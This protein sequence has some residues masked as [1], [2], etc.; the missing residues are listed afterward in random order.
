[1]SPLTAILEAVDISHLSVPEWPQF[2][3]RGFVFELGYKR[4]VDAIDRKNKGVTRRQMEALW[5]A[6]LKKKYAT[7]DPRPSDEAQQRQVN[8]N[9]CIG[10]KWDMMYNAFLMR[11]GHY[12]ERWADYVESIGDDKGGSR[13]Q[14]AKKADW[15][16]PYWQKK[17]RD[18][19]G[20]DIRSVDDNVYTAVPPTEEIVA[21]TS[22]PSA[23]KLN[24]V[25]PTAAQ[26]AAKKDKLRA[27]IDA[28]GIQDAGGFGRAAEEEPKQASQG[29]GVIMT[30]LDKDV[31]GLDITEKKR[32]RKNRGKKKREAVEKKRKLAEEEKAKEAEKKKKGKGVAVDDDGDEEF[33]EPWVPWSYK[34][35]DPALLDDGYVDSDGD[36]GMAG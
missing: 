16:E 29:L 21:S 25:A 18:F 36:V 27:F 2:D 8:Y 22:S 35:V 24:N 3:F 32:K 30:E 26:M 14:S 10:Y 7:W 33:S 34:E 13:A 28:G 4:F 19:P 23:E 6:M 5:L 9:I 31:A 15:I 11:S 17:S 12:N 1:M 20:M